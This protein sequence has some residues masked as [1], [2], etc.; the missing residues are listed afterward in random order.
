[1]ENI[2]TLSKEFADKWVSALRSGQFE[3][4]TGALRKYLQ[5][6]YCYCANGLAY[7]AN[8]FELIGEV[9]IIFN[10]KTVTGLDINLP[11]NKPLYCAIIDLNDGYHKTFPQ[12]A[13]WLESNVEFI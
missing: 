7:F 4:T 1:M 9:L 6:N 5:G 10:G 8:G 2:Y 13:D 3:Q 11:I 12:I